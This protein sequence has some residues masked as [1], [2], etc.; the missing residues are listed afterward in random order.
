LETA[1][2][3]IIPILLDGSHV[4][5]ET[6]KLVSADGKAWTIPGEG[7]PLETD[8]F[9]AFVRRLSG[10]TDS[11]TEGVPDFLLDPLGDPVATPVDQETRCLDNPS[12][13]TMEASEEDTLQPGVVAHARVSDVMT[14][15]G[16]SDTVLLLPAEKE[17]SFHQPHFPETGLD[18][19]ENRALSMDAEHVIQP[20]PES[21]TVDMPRLLRPVLDAPGHIGTDVAGFNGLE[22]TGGRAV[23]GVIRS[24]QMEGIPGA[25]FETENTD[26]PVPG[27]SRLD[28]DSP[29]MG[30]HDMQGTKTLD[31]PQGMS[32]ILAT[33]EKEK[34]PQALLLSRLIRGGDGAAEKI[35]TRGTLLSNGWDDFRI[36]PPAHDGGQPT[37]S[38]GKKSGIQ[39]LLFEPSGPQ[40]NTRPLSAKL[41]VPISGAIQKSDSE[42]LVQAEKMT[43]PMLGSNG[44]MIS[45]KGDVMDISRVQLEPRGIQTLADIIEK[46][47]WRQENGESQ[48]RI[49]LKPSFLGNLHLNVSM[50]QL[51]VTV[52]IRAENLISRDFLEMNLHVLKAEL[53]ESGLEIEKIDVLVDTDLNNRQEQGKASAHKQEQ[54]A[55][56]HSKEMDVNADEDP[57]ESQSIPLSSG[58]EKRVDCF[59]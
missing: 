16:D 40:Q 26:P 39:N 35:P 56:G 50:N 52:E 15:K 27:R 54:R 7:A 18:G 24:P 34:N 38:D 8:S 32:M 29:L 48:A 33:V 17:I 59:V 13:E 30:R 44:T 47:V 36:A 9:D 21:E 1:P 53:Q 55:N 51:K 49:Q 25:T 23:S 11:S 3:A 28:H 31:P 12:R 45:E 42:Y 4:F 43:W 57:S 46:A 37:L 10:Q 2:G 6:G 58:E 14:K 20:R 22:T 41:D 5:S 19:F